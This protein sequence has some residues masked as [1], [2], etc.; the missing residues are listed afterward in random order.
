MTQQFDIVATIKARVPAG[1]AIPKPDTRE[2][3]RVK[4]WGQRRNEGALI[5]Q[6]P[7]KKD[8]GRPHEKGITVSEWRAAWARLDKAGELSRLWFVE[9]LPACN[10]EGACNFTTVGGVFVLLG[11]ARHERGRYVRQSHQDP[12]QLPALIKR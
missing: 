3:H 9:Y 1:T 8:P 6:M 12:Q 5:Y 10:N 7:N 2:P 4:G 11:I